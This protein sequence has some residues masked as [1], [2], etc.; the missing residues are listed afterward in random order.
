M[1]FCLYKEGEG[2]EY[3]DFSPFSFDMISEIAAL[4]KS[5]MTL[6]W[7]SE[8]WRDSLSLDEHFHLIYCPKKALLAFHLNPLD[9]SIHL[10]KIAV[11]ENLKGSG[12]SKRLFSKFIEMIQISRIG[13]QEIYLEVES[14]NLRAISFYNHLGFKKIHLKKSFYSN[15]DDAVIMTL[16]LKG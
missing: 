5:L 8:Q 16:S 9:S 12:F 2:L 3:S 10:Y 15:G 11:S 13:L 4:D 7:S 6:N 1:K 14:K